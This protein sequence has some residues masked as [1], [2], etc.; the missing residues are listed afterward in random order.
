VRVTVTLSPATPA[1]ACA[2]GE[3]RA[4]PASGSVVRLGVLGREATAADAL[5]D[6][7]RTDRYSWLPATTVLPTESRRVG[8]GRFA[9]EVHLVPTLGVRTDRRCGADPSGSEGPRVCLTAGTGREVGVCC[10]TD[11]A[12][13]SGRALALTGG[14]GGRPA[15][16]VH[17]IVPDR[18]VR[19]RVVSGDG[20]TYWVVPEL[21]CGVVTDNDRACVAVEAEFVEGAVCASQADIAGRGV[22]DWYLI[23]GRPVNAGFAPRGA[24]V[25]R[26]SVPGYKPQVFTVRAGV[27]AGTLPEDVRMDRPDAYHLAFAR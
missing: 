8:L 18:V 23:G 20:L 1:E 3:Q 16:E 5:P 27:F 14:R 9:A 21:H 12:I 15:G 11:E 26:V 10:F 17:G 13:Q 7:T 24:A 22:S 19:V 25:A 4:I 2:R 6:V